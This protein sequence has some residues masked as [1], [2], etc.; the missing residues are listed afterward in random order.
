MVKMG[1]RKVSLATAWWRQRTVRDFV[2]HVVWSFG[3][4]GEGRS[5]GRGEEEETQKILFKTRIELKLK[6]KQSRAS[7]KWRGSMSWSICMIT[8]LNSS[9]VIH[10]IHE[11]SNFSSPWN[12][13]EYNDQHIPSFSLSPLS[14]SLFLWKTSTGQR[15][16]IWI[17]M[18][19]APLSSW[20]FT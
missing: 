10:I 7:G 12:I 3:G 18:R 20:N 9:V 11:T 2:A 13:M 6:K 14:L 16:G 8:R 15:I 19:K 1:L 4:K 5:R 17:C